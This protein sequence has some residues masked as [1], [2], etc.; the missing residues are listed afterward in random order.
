MTICEDTQSRHRSAL[1]PL[2]ELVLFLLIQGVT[3]IAVGFVA[4]FWLMPPPSP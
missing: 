3:V 2:V 1:R 4:L